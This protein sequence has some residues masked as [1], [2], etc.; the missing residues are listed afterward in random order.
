M[1]KQHV[2]QQ[3]QTD[4]S[5]QDDLQPCDKSFQEKDGFKKITD[6]D[7]IF[8]ELEKDEKKGDN[9]KCL[10]CKPWRKWS[11]DGVPLHVHLGNPQDGTNIIWVSWSI[12]QIWI[13]MGFFPK[14][15][16]NVN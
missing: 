1:W 10:G 15:S 13:K 6:V 11:G 2:F 16:Q 12:K 8:S 5:F 3:I 7:L 14:K 9:L 4:L